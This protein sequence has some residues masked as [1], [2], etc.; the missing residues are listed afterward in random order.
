MCLIGSFG[1]FVKQKIEKPEVLYEEVVEVKERLVLA[2]DS[3]GISYPHH[4]IVSGKSEV[5]VS[6]LL[7]M[8]GMV[9]L[10]LY[11]D[12]LISYATFKKIF[13]VL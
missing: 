13:C 4:G 9:M 11:A 1:T 5:K 3:C 8:I 10:I 2:Q 12:S 6:S 7:G